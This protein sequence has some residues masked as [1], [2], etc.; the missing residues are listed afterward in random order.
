MSQSCSKPQAIIDLE[1]LYDITIHDSDKQNKPWENNCYY[2][3][4]GQGEVV[5]LTLTNCGLTEIPDLSQFTELTNLSL[6][7]NDITKI[8]NL[9]ALQSLISLNLESNKIEEIEGLDQL[10]KLEYLDLSYN[11]ISLIRNLENLRALRILYLHDNQIKKIEGLRSLH[12]LELCWL[13]SNK[14]SEIAGFDELEKLIWLGLGYNQLSEINGL[15]T[16]KNLKYLFLSGNKISQITGLEQLGN[17]EELYLGDNNI[18][19]IKGLDKLEKLRKL[20]LYD[21]QITKI[22]GISHLKQLT[23]LGLSNNRIT[24]RRNLK[25]LK[26]LVEYNLDGNPIKSGESRLSTQ[27]API[28]VKL[29]KT[30]HK[31]LQ[32]L[33]GTRWLW[34]SGLVITFIWGVLGNRLTN[35]FDEY[36]L[37]ILTATSQHP[38]YA[39]AYT[40]I[41][42]YLAIRVYL[43]IKNSYRIPSPLLAFLGGVCGVYYM[44]RG[45]YVA[46]PDFF[47]IG[48]GDISIFLLSIWVICLFFSQ[49]R[50][51]W[52]TLD[53][54]EQLPSQFI[55]NPIS[56]SQEDRLDYVPVVKRIKQEL[57]EHQLYFVSY[58]I[59]IVAPWGTGKTSFLKLL[60][61]SLKDKIE[62]QELVLVEFNPRLSKSSSHVQEDFFSL[63]FSALR[64]YDLRF[65]HVFHKYLRA[66]DVVGNGSIFSFKLSSLLDREV[67]KEH[68]NHA[69]KE[70]N[71]PIIVLIDDLDRLE[72]N[73]I[74]E[75]F[76]LIRGNADFL[77]VIF[78]VAYD[79]DYV[80][81]ML[82]EIVCNKDLNFTDKF[83]SR[84]ITLP[85]RPR[86][87]WLGK[88]STDLCAAFEGEESLIQEIKKTIEELERYLSTYLPT[89]RAVK[90]FLDN[91]IP[92]FRQVKNDLLFRDYFILQLIRH[93]DY[94]CYTDLKNESLTNLE[95]GVYTLPEQ[96]SNICRDL[97]SLLFPSGNCE[98][99]LSDKNPRSIWQE[100]S[101]HLYFYESPYG[102]I[103]REE[104]ED[105][106]I[107][108]AITNEIN[109]YIQRKL[110][111]YGFYHFID[112]L[113]IYQQA[114]WSKE[115]LK[116]YFTIVFCLEAVAN[117]ENELNN[118]ISGTIILE[119]NI[120]RMHIDKE[121][122]KSAF[123]EAFWDTGL[124]TG[125]NALVKFLPDFVIK[126]K[127]DFDS[128][129]SI[130]EIREASNKL[131]ERIL[132]E[133]RLSRQKIMELF[134]SHIAI[135]DPN[136]PDNTRLILRDKI[137][138]NPREYL[139]YL[140]LKDE[141][142]EMQIDEYWE[143]VLS[144]EDLD[145]IIERYDGDNA[146]KIKTYWEELKAI[147]H[148]K[149]NSRDD[150]I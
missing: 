40:V 59:G 137:M 76:K 115:Q 48:Y 129:L 10:D 9:N 55:D 119:K 61:E 102:V 36:L 104:I 108:G 29:G 130:A 132:Q 39:S 79:K 42:L 51:T 125:Y 88:L 56:S 124:V 52:R 113:K 112:A 143:Q 121:I 84:E 58:S 81:K 101:F 19:K 60:K 49:I 147:E 150:L 89:M 31:L 128:I 148:K 90:R 97:L 24:Q 91:F 65:S 87:I 93:R 111:E 72:A 68:I 30:L 54:Q 144:V 6:N 1:R 131:F 50:R 4:N 105:L 43:S 8:N 46:R 5:S 38:I 23:L 16:L 37:P 26:N 12:L 120:E 103:K 118:E 146:Q 127:S 107:R 57:L 98:L 145:Q 73:E 86:R 138:D 27:L 63:F 94:S 70:I 149:I 82:S 140:F 47:S 75:V 41:M 66:I 18:S 35:I 135:K 17:L 71:K 126:R 142:G 80:N 53:L 62:R 3:C 74:L 141:K 83:C 106:I 100:R 123:I 64:K 122:Y 34:L 2:G 134:R 116:V 25:T 11:K 21:N 99:R 32:F 114:N 78:I 69:L 96:N 13:S 15:R 85:L 14:I 67:E 22:E 28:I 136:L 77:N 7:K 44:N 92:A 95:N 45:R 110:G 133:K 33:K 117:N 109:D 139:E 20:Y